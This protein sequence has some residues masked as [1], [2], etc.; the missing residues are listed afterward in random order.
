MGG[1]DGGVLEVMFDPV[2]VTELSD[3]TIENLIDVS[4][5][6]E[7]EIEEFLQQLDQDE[8]DRFD[9]VDW[10]LTELSDNT[11]ENLIDVSELTEEEIEGFLQQLDQDEV[12]RKKRS[13]DEPEVCEY[14][15]DCSNDIRQVC[16][17][18]PIEVCGKVEE[19]SCVDDS[20]E[21]CTLVKIKVAKK[22]CQEP[23]Y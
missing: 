16:E 14:V 19:E 7:E 11:K 17:E 15:K 13:Y 10:D 18:V 2:D 8:V 21:H 3:N 12:D 6:T 5:L 1:V 23:A 20:S 9:P 4:E 22:I